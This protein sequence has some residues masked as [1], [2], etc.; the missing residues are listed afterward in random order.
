MPELSKNYQELKELLDT[1]GQTR[2]LEMYGTMD[3]IYQIQF[4]FI[5]ATCKYYDTRFIIHDKSVKLKKE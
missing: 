5:Y 4:Q 3:D 1:F 2:F